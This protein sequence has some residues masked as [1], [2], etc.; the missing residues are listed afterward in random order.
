MSIQTAPEQSDYEKYRGKC[1][2]LSEARIAADPSLMLVRGYYHCPFWGKQPHWWTKG[3]DGTINDPTRD[4]FPSRGCGEY[5]EFNGIIE[6]S[7][8]GK[9]MTEEE[10]EIEGNYAFCSYKCHGRF[11]GMF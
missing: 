10:A 8:C 9:E 3:A 5:E 11:V 1:K 6:C 4:Q 2:E 7:N